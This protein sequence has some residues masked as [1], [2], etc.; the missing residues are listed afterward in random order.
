MRELFVSG[1]ENFT[2]IWKGCLRTI[3][4]SDRLY[5]RVKL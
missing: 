2:V 3:V 4:R 1:G 5:N